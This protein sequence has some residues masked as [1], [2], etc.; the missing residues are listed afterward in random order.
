MSNK[1]KFGFTRATALE[2]GNKISTMPYSVFA[3]IKVGA[4]LFQVVK[5]ILKFHAVEYVDMNR[6]IFVLK[7]CMADLADHAESLEE[8]NKKLRKAL[9]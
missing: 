7:G 8:E 9:M 5:D 4:N 1:E 3:D 6:E 2:M